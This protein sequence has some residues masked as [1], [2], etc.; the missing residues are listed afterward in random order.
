[1]TEPVGGIL[2]TSF[3]IAVERRRTTKPVTLPGG[4]AVSV[5]TLAELRL[6]VLNESDGRRQARRLDTLERAWRIRPIGIDEVIAFQW[7][8]LRSATRSQSPSRVNDLWIAATAL[9]LQVP[10][11]TQ[12]DGFRRL[13]EVGGPRVIQ[14]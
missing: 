10:V 14:L 13:E 12:D 4:L 11:I 6:A 3:F 5:V 2:D 1:L 8:V 9:A 7:A